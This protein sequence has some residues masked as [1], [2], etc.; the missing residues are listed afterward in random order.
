MK[1]IS[2]LR[3]LLSAL[4]LSLAVWSPAAHASDFVVDT[5]T[6][7]PFTPVLSL[8]Q[9][10][11]S[12]TDQYRFVVDS[13]DPVNGFIWAFPQRPAGDLGLIY[14]TADLTLTLVNADTLALIG[15]GVKFA[16]LPGFNPA[17]PD[18]LAE[19]QQLAQGGYD[20]ASSVFWSGSLISGNYLA[21]VTGFA[22]GSLSALTG[23]G[24]G[25]TS[26]KFF[27]PSIPEPTTVAM[28]VAGLAMGG[29]SLL[30]RR[31]V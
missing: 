8:I 6:A 20:L 16:D 17:D 27:I 3:P 28:L 19:A 7:S 29:L 22:G 18:F 14:G 30:R 2:A 23:Q 21:T 9:Q 4:A 1:P 5:P 25:V 31:V 11:G 12:F 24:G 10:P 26:T 13:E 15:T